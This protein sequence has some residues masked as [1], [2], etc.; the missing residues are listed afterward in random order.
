MH[1]TNHYGE[2]VKQMEV[3]RADT[4]SI[5]DGIDTRLPEINRRSQLK[6]KQAGRGVD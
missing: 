2:A 5:V 3:V 4:T 1:M 6:H